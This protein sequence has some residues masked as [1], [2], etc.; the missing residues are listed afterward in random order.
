[1]ENPGGKIKTI[2]DEIDPALAFFCAIF[3][4]VCIAF[5]WASNAALLPPPMPRQRA[6]TPLVYSPT[7][8]ACYR[9]FTEETKLLEMEKCEHIAGTSIV[10]APNAIECWVGEPYEDTSRELWVHSTNDMP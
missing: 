8:S 3:A 7:T 1:M 6:E 9:V 2:L 10:L 4:A 5:W